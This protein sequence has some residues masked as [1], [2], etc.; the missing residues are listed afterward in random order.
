MQQASVSSQNIQ[1][2]GSIAGYED[3]KCIAAPMTLEQLESN[4]EALEKEFNRR[5]HELLAEYC[6]S[7]NTVKIG[8]IVRDTVTIIRV[9]TITYWN[10]SRKPMCVYNGIELTKS[11][12]PRKDGRKA[13]VYQGAMI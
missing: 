4:R 10:S 7:N 6:D 3:I 1:T 8:D 11:L 13:S 5:S 12:Q 9:E 2:N